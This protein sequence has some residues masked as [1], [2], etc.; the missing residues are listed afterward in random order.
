MNKDGPKEAGNKDRKQIANHHPDILLGTSS[1]GTNSPGLAEGATANNLCAAPA[2]A[3]GRTHPKRAGAQA[4]GHV[5]T[6]KMPGKGRGPQRKGNTLRT[7][8]NH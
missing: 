7:E 4:H 8:K 5:Q 1:H 3:D 2:E 6:G